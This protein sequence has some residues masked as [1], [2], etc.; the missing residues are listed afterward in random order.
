MEL[1]IRDNVSHVN[2]PE[3]KGTVVAFSEK[4]HTKLRTVLVLW[5]GESSFSRHTFSALKKV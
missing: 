4:G 1:K 3:K 5:A 2:F